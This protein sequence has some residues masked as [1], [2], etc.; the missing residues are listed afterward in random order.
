MSWTEE[1]GRLQS[2]ESQ[3]WTQLKQLSMHARKGEW[4]HMNQIGMKL[5]IIEAEWW[6]FILSFYLLLY[7]FKY[8]HNQKLKIS[9]DYFQGY[10]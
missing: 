10:L 2:V 8:S 6:W 5:I 3:R 9:K 1:P 7:M 4:K